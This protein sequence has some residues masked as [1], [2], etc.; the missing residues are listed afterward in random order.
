MKHRNNYLIIIITG[1]IFLLISSFISQTQAAETE[2]KNSAQ[3]RIKFD[4]KVLDFGNVGAGTKPTGEF[5]FKNIGNA[6]LVISKVSQCC[7][8][9]TSYEKETYE[10]NESGVI[11]VV[12]NAS[13][14]PGFF[15]RNPIVSSNDPNEPNLALTV[16]AQIVDKISKN[17]EKL[18]LFLDEE[19]AACPKLI[20]TSTDNQPFSIR[21]IESTGDCITTKFDISTKSKEFTLDLKV[22][23]EKLKEN[24]H[25][26]VSIIVTHP[27]MNQILIPYDVLSRFTVTPPLLIVSDAESNVSVG[28]KIWVFNNYNMEFEIESAVSE[29]KYIKV[30][31]T[32]KV[33]NGYQLEL[34][35]TPPPAGDKLSFT[36]K[37]II[38]IKDSEKLTINCNGYYKRQEE[39]EK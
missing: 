6:P 24:M 19:N 22:D 7:G 31:N 9:V 35:I 2:N 11:S 34:E 30:L 8:I 15:T 32:I 33:D 37:L 10:P 27:E 3:P 13:T 5:K 21:K 1:F 26:E 29:N 25:G 38:Q 36:D 23:I 18:K 14:I 4:D 39:T 17:P 12:Y 16:K 28:R 20:I